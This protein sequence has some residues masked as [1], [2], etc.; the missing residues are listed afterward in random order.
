ML[1]S[2]PRIPDDLMA[3]MAEVGPTWKVN[4][5]NNILVMLDRFSD[6]LKSMPRDGVNV[7]RDISYGLHPRNQ[8]DLY[9]PVG[10]GAKRSI[11]LFVHGGAF[12][13]GHRNR[14]DQIYSNVS[15]Y[16]ARNNITS[17]NI[18]YRLGNDAPFPAGSDDISAVVKWTHE[19]AS[20]LGIDRSR[21]FLMGHSAG[22]AHAGSYAYDKRRHPADGPGIAGLIVVSGRVRAETLAEN[23]NADRVKAYYGTDNAA[24][25][26]DLSP[27]SHVDANSVPTFVAF[28]EFENPLIDVHCTELAFRLA[29]AKRRAPPVMS[30][31]GH[32]HTSMIGHI[33]TA[34][35]KLGQAMLEFI[36]DP[37]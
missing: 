31:R 4:R 28:G 17:I 35:E 3:L 34:D 19:N 6:V 9:T 2:L 10:S 5:A 18:G 12:M 21:V 32:N 11:V 33:G 22:A 25:L 1:K 26:N 16:F 15:Y 14:S 27:I 37:R 8:F 29:D 36:A 23:P 24:V 7:R 13:D 30:L 20:E